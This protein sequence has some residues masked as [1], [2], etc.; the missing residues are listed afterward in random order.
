[1]VDLCLL[2]DRKLY[3]FAVDVHQE[4]SECE[5]GESSSQFV[6]SHLHMLGMQ[7]DLILSVYF[8][9]KFL[10]GSAIPV[11]DEDDLPEYVKPYLK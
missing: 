1:M 7:L 3:A 5:A 8:R 10:E 9:V 4:P 11:I 6:V 2:D